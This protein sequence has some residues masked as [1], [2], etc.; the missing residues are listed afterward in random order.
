MDEIALG[1]KFDTNTSNGVII[2]FTAGIANISLP[3]VIIAENDK[4]A[5]EIRDKLHDVFLYDI[6]LQKKG[7]L[8]YRDYV[9]NCNINESVNSAYQ[10]WTSFGDV[11][12]NVTTDDPYWRKAETFTFIADGENSEGMQSALD[13]EY[14]FNYDYGFTHNKMLFYNKSFVDSNF[15]M[16]IQGE[17][18]TPIVFINEHMY[19][20][21]VIL[22]SGDVLEI[23]SMNHAHTIT[24]TKTNGEIQNCFDLRNRESYIFEK[25]CTGSN[26][27]H[28]P[29]KLAINLT[30]FDERGEPKWN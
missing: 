1:W 26:T 30:V 17:I 2:S 5:N 15:I 9:L 28:T 29:Q 4:Q 10:E 24:L 13:Y 19:S 6:L 8:I 18:D 11:K 20:V 25:I 23:N 21:D 7:K 22:E 3:G 27:L 16:K 14:D 12:L